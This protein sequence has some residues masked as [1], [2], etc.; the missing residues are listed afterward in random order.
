MKDSKKKL[1]NLEKMVGKYTNNRAEEPS[2]NRVIQIAKQIKE[3]ESEVNQLKKELKNL[4][5]N[6]EHEFQKNDTIRVCKKC[7]LI[8]SL[9][10]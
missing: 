2:M 7:H 8:E 5:K 6:C 10:W 1:M 3:L 4:Q 9:Y